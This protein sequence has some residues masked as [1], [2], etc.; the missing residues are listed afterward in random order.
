VPPKPSAQTNI[1]LEAMSSKTDEEKGRWDQVM[2]GF[3]LLFARV[4]DIGLIQQEMKK[5]FQDQREAQRVMSQQVQ[6]SGQAVATL[7]LRTMEA[8]AQYDN[9]EEE[10]IL[11]EEEHSFTN[12]FGKERYCRTLQKIQE[13]ERATQDRL[14]ATPYSA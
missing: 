10:Y 13:Q 1:I 2:E 3:D 11:S 12:V 8:E 14:F 6:A 9:L 4:N 7:T 5:D